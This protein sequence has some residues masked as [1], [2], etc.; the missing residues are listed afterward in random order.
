MRLLDSRVTG[1]SRWHSRAVLS[2]RALEVNHEPLIWW[3]LQGFVRNAQ[4]TMQPKPQWLHPTSLRHPQ[5]ARHL[6]GGSSLYLDRK[7]VFSQLLD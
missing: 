3:P 6:S 7:P 1:D 2:E 4:H 5:E